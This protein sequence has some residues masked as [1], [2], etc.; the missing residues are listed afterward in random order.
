MASDSRAVKAGQ[1]ILRDPRN[2]RHV[3]GFDYEVASESQAGTFY[4]VCLQ[5]RSCEC[6][7]WQSTHDLCKHIAAARLSHAQRVNVPDLNE[8]PLRRKKGPGVPNYDEL[9]K[10]EYR[11]V[12]ELARCLGAVY[13]Y[14]PPPGPGRWPACYGDLLTTYLL[15]RYIGK[16]SRF[17]IPD[18]LMLI[19]HG[20]LQR[21]W[22]PEPSTLR[23][24]LKSAEF[25]AMLRDT[26][27]RTTESIRPYGKD[28][29]ID[30]LTIGTP[31]AEILVEQVANQTRTVLRMRNGK[32]TIAAE[33]ETLMAVGFLFTEEHFSDQHC[34]IPTVDQFR[35]D[36]P[37][38]C[39]G[40]VYADNGYCSAEHY[41]EIALRGAIAWIDF[42]SS[43]DKRIYGPK[44]GKP[45]YN[46]QLALY[47]RDLTGFLAEYHARNLVESLNSSF[48]TRVGTKL[49]NRQEVTL[50][51]EAV[52]M[53]IVYNLIKL[54]AAHWNPDIPKL[55]IPWAD[56]R[57]LDAIHGRLWL[58]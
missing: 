40:N 39:G 35:S 17:A 55:V 25:A 15:A 5:P 29:A 21:D 53:M 3:G 46:Q 42:K 50:E 52:A 18:P 10:H 22:P 28:F 33:T 4:Q 51:N 20:C 6:P 43:T 13:K 24:H 41:E 58:P 12:R 19:S 56:D 26:F 11:A 38:F 23:E 49:R 47:Q 27:R 2:V 54:H 32:F 44:P 31:N 30:G 48:L 34:L 14:T 45:H 8:E 36:F 1:R 7:A 37:G 57:A 9:C 16:S